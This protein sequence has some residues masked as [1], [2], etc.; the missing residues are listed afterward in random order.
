MASIDSEL[1]G[2]KSDI[3]IKVLDCVDIGIGYGYMDMELGIH[4]GMYREWVRGNK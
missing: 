2:M 3:Y 1:G 4:L